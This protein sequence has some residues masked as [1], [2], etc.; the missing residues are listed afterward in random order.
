MKHISKW[1]IPGFL[2]RFDD[3]L[4]ENY[5]VI[6]RT[7]GHFV[8]FYS[9]FSIIL[10]FIG[11]FF[12]PVSLTDPTVDPVQPIYIGI[13]SIPFS[14][15]PLIIG[16]IGV[17]YWA[18][19]QYWL[20]QQDPAPTKVFLTLGIYAVGLFT[21]LAL[22]PISFRMGTIVST[23]YFLMDEKD[24]QHLEENDFFL[25]GMI[26]LNSDDYQEQADTFFQRRAAIFKRVKQFEDTLLQNRYDLPFLV[27][28]GAVDSQALNNAYT[29]YPLDLSRAYAYKSFGADFSS[30]AE[31]LYERIYRKNMYSPTSNK[32][33]IT[34]FILY[35]ANDQKYSKADRSVRFKQATTIN[36]KVVPP[37][38]P[39]PKLSYWNYLPDYQKYYERNILA[40][41]DTSILE[42]YKI[43]P[44]YDT[45]HLKDFNSFNLIKSDSLATIPKHIYQLE[46]GVRSVKNARQYLQ[47]S[48]WLRYLWD[49]LINFSLLY[50]VFAA[51]PY[52]S[53][54]S[55]L[56]VL[57]V[58]IGYFIGLPSL[59][60]SMEFSQEVN[61]YLNIF[62]IRFT[63]ILPVIISLLALSFFAIKKQ[64]SN[65]P[66]IIF[67]FLT[68][69]ILAVIIGIN[70]LKESIRP[71]YI[72]LFCTHLLGVAGILLIAHIS[73]QPKSS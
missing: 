22:I 26:L 53:F 67:Q 43:T 18:Y 49:L 29:I 66:F 31:G 50:L 44:E 32:F 73:A 61:S 27:Q 15:I 4:L 40:R 33:S 37:P 69:S 45:V 55:I 7:R 68:V 51:S 59:S 60:I 46:D 70:F 13:D 11:G 25:Y 58:Y 19:L 28:E 5:P 56:A 2:R 62:P 8:L 71:D 23:A 21:I 64:R 47:K 57:V 63:Y 17:L 30:R 34:F 41:F 16:V 54:R 20:F 3:Y 12:Y 38:P 52:L 48:V 42:K 35:A 6:W 36:G 9:V 14:L 1:L 72:V 10:L 24:I 39:K 65:V